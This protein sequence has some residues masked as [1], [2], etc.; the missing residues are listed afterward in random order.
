MIDITHDFTLEQMETGIQHIV[1]KLE[2]A[3][4]ALAEG[5]VIKQV[6]VNAKSRDPPSRQS[7]SKTNQKCSYCSGEHSAHVAPSIKLYSLARIG[8]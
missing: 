2:Q 8:F 3:M 5:A 6:G 7:K 1:D 4:L